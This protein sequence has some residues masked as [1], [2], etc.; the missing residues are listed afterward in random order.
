MA[1]ISGDGK[2]ILLALNPRV[3]TG[4]Q[5][6]PY[7]TLTQPAVVAGGSN[8]SFTITLPT[9]RTQEIST[10]VAVKSGE[11]V[12]MGGVLEREKTSLC[13][14]GAGPGRHSDSRRAVP[15]PHGYGYAALPA[16]FCNSYDREG[17]RRIPRLR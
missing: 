12:V 16:G 5:L 10:R 6:V 9:Y 15:A 13:R 11:T 2:S 7:A 17:Y 14:V 1:S 8:S 4:V 3:N